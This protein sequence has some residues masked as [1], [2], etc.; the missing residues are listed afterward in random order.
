MNNVLL[1]AMRRPDED[2]AIAVLRALLEA[3][4]HPDSRYKADDGQSALHFAVS[5][6]LWDCARLLIAHGASPD[7]S[8]Q[9]CVWS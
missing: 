6:S 1:T 9:V 4:V 3:G 2:Q 5:H 7:L 8:Y